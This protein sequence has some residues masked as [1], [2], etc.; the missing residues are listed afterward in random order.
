MDFPSS[1]KYNKS[2][3]NFTSTEAG[4]LSLYAPNHNVTDYIRGLRAA[5]GGGSTIGTHFNGNGDVQ[6]GSKRVYPTYNCQYCQNAVSIERTIIPACGHGGY[7]LVPDPNESHITTNAYMQWHWV[8]E[9]EA[10]L[11]LI[12]GCAKFCFAA[13][14]NS[15]VGKNACANNCNN[16]CTGSTTTPTCDM[17]TGWMNTST[18]KYYAD[19][20]NACFSEVGCLQQCVRVV[21]VPCYWCFNDTSCN[22]CVYNCTSGCANAT[23][24]F[25]EN[26]HKMSTKGHSIVATRTCS[27]CNGM[28]GNCNTVCNSDTTCASCTAGCTTDCTGGCFTATVSGE[29]AKSCA[30]NCFGLCTESCTCDCTASYYSGCARNNYTWA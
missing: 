29:C 7:S 9:S 2:Y 23:D 17:Y 25:S 4:D 21:G 8:S 26:C 13:C 5:K 11:S 28:T 19:C 30:S 6:Y 14:F 12:N 10:N 24:N 27:V 16:S 3:T 20:L 1:V 15:F 22:G 18:T